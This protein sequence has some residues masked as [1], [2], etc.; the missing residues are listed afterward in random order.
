M[1][2]ITKMIFC[3]LQSRNVFSCPL[4]QADQVKM[5][6][7]LTAQTSVVPVLLCLKTKY[8]TSGNVHTTLLCLYILP[9]VYN[10]VVSNISFFFSLNIDF[11]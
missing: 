8:C 5:A 1:K 10:D 4:E 2:N 6:T 3:D 7:V 9:T 11:V